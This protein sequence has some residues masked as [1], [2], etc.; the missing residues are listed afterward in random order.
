M[1]KYVLIKFP[2]GDQFKIPAKVIADSRA[3]YYANKEEG[4]QTG[5]MH[6]TEEW[7]KLYREE[8]DITEEDDYELTD[9]L[10]NNMDWKDVEKRVIRVTQPEK[11]D[12]AN[13]WM[14]IQNESN[15]EVIKE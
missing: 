15:Y 6:P 2:N 12:Y 14:A 13:H 8:F 5:T 11:Y 9:W 4:D 10:W 3:T 7:S 1:T